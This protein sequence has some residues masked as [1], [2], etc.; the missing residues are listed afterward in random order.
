[1][2]YLDPERMQQTQAGAFQQRA[3]F[4]WMNFDGLLREDAFRRLLESVPNLDSF[5]KETERKGGSGVRY[6][7]Q[8]RPWLKVAEP[9]REFIA[10]LQG[11]EYMGFIRR[12]FGLGEREELE[13]TM[14]WHFAPRGFLLGPHVDAKRKV[15]SHIFYLNTSDD[16]EPSWGGQT[17][18]LDDGG[19]SLSSPD[20]GDFQSITTP[21]IVGNR[22]LLF[23]RTQHS[24]HGVKALECPPEKLRKVFIVVFNR[25][26]LQV[27]W[28]RI[29][30]KDP[31][32]YPLAPSA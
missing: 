23:Q 2:Q 28:R 32:G 1:M 6:D 15:G 30:G 9:W 24:W 10:E 29:R 17:L 4:P 14:H 13:L 16:W 18:I 3:P 7:L 27:R 20:F 8:Y 19:R 25:R 26:T 11:S 5:G 21:E 12:L 22:S 31:D